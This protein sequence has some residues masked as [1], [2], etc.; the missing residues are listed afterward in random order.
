MMPAQPALVDSG[1]DFTMFPE[2]WAKP[3][4]I[5]LDQCQ[6]MPG[7][8]AAGKDD[9]EDENCPRLYAPGLDAVVA[10][11]KV[12]LHALFRRG[13]PVILLGREDFFEYFKVSFDQRR[14]SFVIEIYDS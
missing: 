14:K 1:C 4:G 6:P 10:G 12:H 9:A 11:H 5:D 7:Y 2:E 13:L 3:L 8:T